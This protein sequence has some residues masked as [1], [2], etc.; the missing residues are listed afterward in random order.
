[1]Y[2]D[3]SNVQPAVRIRVNASDFDADPS[4]PE[5]WID[6][7]GE[8]L[9]SLPGRRVY[10]ADAGGLPV[11]VKEYTPGRFLDYF[12]SRASEEAERA[13]A[14]KN[15]GIPVVEAVAFARYANGVERLFLRE[16]A[17]A[18]SLSD[19]VLSGVARG[20]ARHELAQRVGELIAKLHSEGFQHRD[21]HAGNILV[22]PDGEVLFADAAGLRPGHYLR[23]RERARSL[24]AFAPFFLTHASRTDLLLFWGAYGRA[25][26]LAPDD[27]ERLRGHA[28]E[29]IPG[30]F[31]DLTRRRARAE[32]TR[33]TPVAL[34]GFRGVVTGE[35]DSLLLE[36]I[37]DAARDLKRAP[38]VLKRSRSG[39]TF[40][41]GTG[42]TEYVVKVYLPKKITRSLRD[43]FLGTRAE[44]AQRAAHALRH[45]GFRTPEVVAVLTDPE[46]T[47]RS[48]LVTRFARGFVPVDECAP[49]LEPR[50]ARALAIQFGRLLRR[51]HDW[52]LRHRDLK[53]D[54]FLFSADGREV[55]FLDLDGVQEMRSGELPWARRM[56]D[57]GNLAGSLL[58]R[59]AVPTGLRLRALAAYLG[60]EDPPGWGPGEFAWKTVEKAK[61]YQ[62]SK[63]TYL[64]TT[65]GP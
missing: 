14:A 40:T 26:G 65:E 39:W 23:E 17:G 44:R 10:R 38:N 30:A 33:G 45:R 55:M 18:R 3:P 46:G 8:V 25:S 50:R 62:R 59:N 36:Q 4:Q 31:R 34:G 35:I 49:H 27:L 32:R 28:M 43:F 41:T 9:R 1:M 56:R 2:S 52:G 22:K 6:H 53:K 15:R 57:L 24:A 12:R 60:D 5:S 61:E 42:S 54:N 29:K 48:I 13:E 16:V 7:E 64:E 20:G 21:L 58:D 37:V 47:C 51:M 11:V 19:V 63:L